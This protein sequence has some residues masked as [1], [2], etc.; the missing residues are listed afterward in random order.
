M[1]KIQLNGNTRTLVVLTEIF[2]DTK[3]TISLNTKY[4]QYFMT[5]TKVD[6]AVGKKETLPFNAPDVSNLVN[7]IN[8][9]GNFV[10]QN[11]IP[12]G[13]ENIYF[14]DHCVSFCVDSLGL[15]YELNEDDR[16]KLIYE[17]LFI[18]KI[19]DK[20]EEDP[21]LL[22]ILNSLYIFNI[23]WVNLYR[24]LE[25]IES[26]KINV[27]KEGWISESDYKLFKYTANSPKAI[28]LQSRHGKGEKNSPKKPMSIFTARFLIKTLIIKYIE[29]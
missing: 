3:I 17:K 20:I 6:Q 16:N 29:K 12:I 26:A 27:V 28:G 9:I 13:L 7:E 4:Q 8:F 19:R 11:Y 24:I 15:D 21:L 2:S 18:N 22:K 23:D 25:L 10:F 1:I 14:D 5:G